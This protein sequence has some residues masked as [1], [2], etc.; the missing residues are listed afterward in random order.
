MDLFSP[1]FYGPSMKYGGH[2]HKEEKKMIHSYLYGQIKQA[3]EPKID[4]SQHAKAI[5][6]NGYC[7]SEIL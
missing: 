7:S 3:L 2:G 1:C 6:N 4:Q 5:S